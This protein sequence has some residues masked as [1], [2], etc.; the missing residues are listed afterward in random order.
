MKFNLSEFFKGFML[1]NLP[2]Y[3]FDTNSHSF[4]KTFLFA[5]KR[6]ISFMIP[7]KFLISILLI[8]H[9]SM[10]LHL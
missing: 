6:L 3:K 1:I 8:K 5:K 9:F 7:P 4:E 2:Y 10:N